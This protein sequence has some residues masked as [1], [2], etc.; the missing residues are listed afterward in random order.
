[1]LFMDGSGPDELQRHS[2]DKLSQASSPKMRAFQNRKKSPQHKHS[3]ARGSENTSNAIND[4]SVANQGKKKKKKKRAHNNS[5]SFALKEMVANQDVDFY[6]G[7]SNLGSQ[8]DYASCSDIQ[9]QLKRERKRT[10]LKENL[11]TYMKANGIV[12]EVQDAQI[13][14]NLRAGPQDVME[15]KDNKG[16]LLYRRDSFKR[17]LNNDSLKYHENGMQEVFDEFQ[18]YSIKSQYLINTKLKNTKINID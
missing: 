11:V 7:Q 8:D 5:D 15:L 17:L 16:R 6:G 2:Q 12:D 13:L 18:K 14:Q 9:T 10:Q 3:Q 4:I 1:M